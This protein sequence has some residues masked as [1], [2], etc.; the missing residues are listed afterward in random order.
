MSNRSLRKGHEPVHLQYENV[1]NT[2]TAKEFSVKLEDGILVLKFTLAPSGENQH[3]DEDYLHEH[4]KLLSVQLHDEFVI[5]GLFDFCSLHAGEFTNGA[6]LEIISKGKTLSYQI[7]K[8]HR[9]QRHFLQLDLET[10]N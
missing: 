4:P 8:N 7:T 2:I 5:S 3:I 1:G 10:L 6:H 9:Q